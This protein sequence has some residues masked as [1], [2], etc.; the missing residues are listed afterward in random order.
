MEQGTFAIQ[1][2]LI[3]TGTVNTLIVEP[4]GIVIVARSFIRGLP[5]SGCLGGFGSLNGSTL[6]DNEI[7]YQTFCAILVQIEAVSIIRQSFEEFRQLIEIERF[8]ARIAFL[9]ESTGG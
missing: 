6:F 2:P 1:L 3:L 9:T 5:C 8:E 4:L 7:E